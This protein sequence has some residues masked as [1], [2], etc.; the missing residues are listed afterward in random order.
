[1]ND[2]GLNTNNKDNDIQIAI[3]RRGGHWIT[4]AFF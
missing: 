3:E 1:M 2:A 4:Y